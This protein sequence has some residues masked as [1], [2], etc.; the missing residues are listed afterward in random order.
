MPKMVLD[1][2]DRRPAWSMPSW[3]PE[4]I[5]GALPRGW[6]LHVMET[7][8]DGSGDGMANL[9]PALLDAAREAEIYLGYG[10][11]AALLR[12]GRELRW[13][14]SGAAGVRGSLTPEMLASRVLFTN[15]RGIHGPPMADTALG[16]ILH[17]SRGLDF[18]IAAK[19]RG[20]WEKDPFYAADNPLVELAFSTVGVF[21]FGGIGREV[22]KRV[23]AL[24]ARLLAFDRGPEAVEDSNISLQGVEPLH[25]PRGFQ[26][27]LTE[28]D[29][30][31]I[32]AALSRMKPGAT[33]LNISRGR[34]VDE[35]A[36]VSALTDGRLRGAGL[37][38]F[39]EEPLPEDHPLWALPNVLILPHV[40]A[41]SRHFWRRQADLILENL[42]RYLEG[43]RLLNLVDKAAGF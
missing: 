34:L 4:E 12:E 40:S 22:G 33:L 9:D 10:V 15:S 6:E 16:M 43:E 14:H 24:G 39:W 19:A 5:R 7:D 35:A 36:L 32:A 1:L 37:D 8:A 26:R 30:L 11:P 20:R 2:N 27:L 38:V 29:F 18:G 42:R 41:V 31:V 25:G 21:G 17:F 13:V 23:A 28:S 3:V